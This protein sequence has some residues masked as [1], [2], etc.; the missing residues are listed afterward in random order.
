MTLKYPQLLEKTPFLIITLY[1][2]L[3]WKAEP[4]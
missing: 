3:G 4:P 1:P 2:A